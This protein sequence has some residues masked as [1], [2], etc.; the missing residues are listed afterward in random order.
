MVTVGADQ[1]PHSAPRGVKGVV[2][3]GV[4]R[5]CPA[6]FCIDFPAT[7][8]QLAFRINHYGAVEEQAT[9][10]VLLGKAEAAKQTVF[11]SQRSKGLKRGTGG[12][13]G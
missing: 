4:A 8:R 7:E 9:C 6:A 13:F 5:T 11:L 10:L 1:N 2:G 12:S 3:I